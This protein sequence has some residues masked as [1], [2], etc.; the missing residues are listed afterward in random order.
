M[1]TLCGIDLDSDHLIRLL[2]VKCWVGVDGVYLHHR[3]TLVSK[4]QT[5]KRS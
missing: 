5:K 2:I 4:A 3:Q 1:Q